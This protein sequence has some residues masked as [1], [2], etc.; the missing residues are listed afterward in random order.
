MGYSVYLYD[1]RG[2]G[3]STRLVSG[4]DVRHVEHFQDYVDDLKTFVDQ[5][6]KGASTRKIVLL[7]HSAGGAQVSL[8]MEQFAGSVNGAILATPMHGIN[9]KGFPE[10]FALSLANMACNQGKDQAYALTQRAWSPIV[11][12]GNNLSHSKQRLETFAGV[13]IG[14]PQLRVGGASNRWTVEAIMGIRALLKNAAQATDPILL[15]QG[16]EDSVVLPEPQNK[17]CELAR[18]CKVQPYTN[19]KHGILNET[20]DIRDRV[21]D[22]IAGFFSSL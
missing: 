16:S 1:Q 12:D 6:V 3:L 2:H 14:N 18:N 4:S 15:L 11:F 10:D 19:A 8:Y 22:A 20:D 5:K 7:G 17:F 21:L 13:T 9:L